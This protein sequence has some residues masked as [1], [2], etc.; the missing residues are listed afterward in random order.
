MDAE[1]HLTQQ[2]TGNGL[3]TANGF[4]ALTGRLTSVATGTGSVV[5]NLSVIYDKRGNPLSRSDAN[6]NLS[7]TF[8]YDG[9]NRLLS[10]TVNLTP[11]PL[12]KTFSYDPIGNLVSKSD[13]G[14]YTYPAAGQ[15][16]PHAVTSISAGVIST[17]FTY[18]LNGNQT[19]GVGRTIAWT[20]YNKPS[21]ITQGTRTISFV[22]DTEHQRFKQVTPEGTKLYLSAFGVSAEV[23]NPGTNSQIWTD[24][25]SVG[26]AMVGMRTIQTA[27]ET[28]ATRY[29]H[30]DHLGSIAVITNEAGAV[31]ERLSY[32]AWGKRRNPNGT[33]DTT[34]SITSQS[35]R[36][37]TGEEQLSVSGLVNLNGRVYDP[38]VARMTSADPTIPKPLSTQGLN[39]YS[40]ASN[41]PVR[42]VD[43]SGFEDGAVDRITVIAYVG[44]GLG[45]G[46]SGGSGGGYPGYDPLA[47]VAGGL[48]GMSCCAALP[49]YDAVA[50]SN[51]LGA[52]VSSM[53]QAG[54]AATA[55]QFAAMNQAVAQ[56]PV[57]IPPQVSQV[58]STPGTPFTPNAQVSA[59]AS[60]PLV[61][62]S[63]YLGGGALGGQ[64]S[65][66]GLA[67]VTSTSIAMSAGAAAAAA[68]LVVATN[69]DISRQDRQYRF[70]HGTSQSSAAALMAGAP[71]M[72]R[73]D[74][75]IDGP[76]GF[77]RTTSFDDA[78]YYYAARRD[79][80]AVLT[81]GVSGTAYDALIEAGS[82]FGPT[83]QGRVR[84]TGMQFLFRQPHFPS[85][86]R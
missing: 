76:P 25:L 23:T 27:S 11:T 49:S 16:Q 55:A 5:Q 47:F 40:Y 74:L 66:S 9:L 62:P 26:D 28:I 8:T 80:G 32:D 35:S 24:Y 58:Q 2:T 50:A 71:L 57:F 15:A 52:S 69:K 60:V 3:V 85:S 38:I 41:R 10:S 70:F 78:Y 46:A 51:A 29:F 14:S 86:T 18:D 56:N 68:A 36:G 1:L 37:F 17:A 33:E 82:T 31:V 7:E 54:N 22:D 30:T 12:A 42:N 72:I 39:R 79:P 13:V 75:R 77:Y 67:A 6:T 43:T 81:V 64:L 21:S 59:F 45:Y 44:V 73:P 20:S 19:S 34:G 65:G 84:L 4:D 53:I 48:P 63:A 83:P 61:A